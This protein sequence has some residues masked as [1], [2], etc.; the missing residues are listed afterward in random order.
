MIVTIICGAAGTSTGPDQAQRAQPGP[1]A[2]P[3]P[4]VAGS[5]ERL[6]YSHRCGRVRLR[7]VSVRNAGIDWEAPSN[8]YWQHKVQRREAVR[9]I[10]HGQSEFEASHVVLQGSHTFEVSLQPSCDWLPDVRSGVCC[11]QMLNC[12]LCY[13]WGWQSPVL[14]ALP[15]ELARGAEGLDFVFFLVRLRILQALEMPDGMLQLSAILACKGALPVVQMIDSSLSLGF[16]R[17]WSATLHAYCLGPLTRCS[18]RHDSFSQ[19]IMHK[20]AASWEESA[21]N[22]RT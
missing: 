3:R 1:A 17:A 10:L 15:S 14:T 18:G 20:D 9:I 6:V 4:S 16:D 22:S 5:S 11:I 7:G 19:V 21:R 8:V 2:F 13:G 12:I